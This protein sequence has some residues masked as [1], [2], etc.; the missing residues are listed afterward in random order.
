M[1]ISFC[2]IT[3]GNKPEIT[4]LCIQS[5]KNNFESFKDYEIIIVGNNIDQ[6][7]GENIKLIEDNKY[8]IFLG[9][10]RNIATKNSVGDIVV[11]C[12][13][14][15][16]FEEDWFKKFKKYE[17][18]NKDW[19]ILGNK[20]LS[21]NGSRYWDRNIYKPNHKMVPYD[22]QSD[23]DTFYQTGGFCI[24]K[25]E[26][27]EKVSWSDDIDFYC[28]NSASNINE[29]VDL[30]IKLKKLSIDIS[31]DKNN[32]VWHYDPTY[33]T[34]GNSVHKCKDIPENLYHKD[35]KKLIK[36]LK[37]ENG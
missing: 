35:F 16:I 18:E 4:K 11:N 30:S 34:I 15:I 36:K 21:P 33:T 32:T 19:L 9:K 6:F 25:K 1:F 31:F 14:D 3:I 2:I 29:D 37:N 17:K 27:F 26:I 20:I 5:I 13:D 12:D 8:K 24:C 7:S 22:Y 10:R 23:S 28:K